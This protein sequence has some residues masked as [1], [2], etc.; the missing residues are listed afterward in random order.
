[1]KRKDMKATEK[2]RMD[3]LANELKEKERQRQ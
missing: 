2:T 1:M 3:R